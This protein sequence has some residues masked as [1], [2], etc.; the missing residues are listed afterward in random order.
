MA[1]AI[2]RHLLETLVNCPSC[3]QRYT[4]PRVLPSCGHTICSICLDNEW[5][6]KYNR[7]CPVKTCHKEICSTIGNLTDLPLNQ[8][9]LDLIKSCNFNVEANGKCQVCNQSPSF[10]KCSHCCL[11]V[12]FEC[13][14]QHRRET[15]TILTNNINTLEQEYLNMNDY[16]NHAR[17]KLTETRQNSLDTIRNHYTRLIEELRHA[18]VTNEELVERQAVTWNNELEL[19]INEYKRRCEDISTTIQEL[20]T[21]IT[22]WST[23]EQFKQLQMKLNH[24]E[25]D[26][27]EAN[28]IFHE[29]LPDMKIFEVDHD[30]IQKKKK[31]I[32][33]IDSPSQ[34]DELILGNGKNHLS[35][36]SGSI[37]IQHLDD[38]TSSA[39]SSSNNEPVQ[40]L[41]S[42]HGRILKKKPTIIGNHYKSLNTL[43]N[44]HHHSTNTSDN[45][46]HPNDVLEQ[47]QQP[48]LSSP[49]TT[50]NHRSHPP[51]SN[52]SLSKTISN[53][54]ADL[55]LSTNNNSKT[56]ST[57][58][59]V[60]TFQS[61]LDY[62]N[63]ECY[64]K[65]PLSQ[66]YD[67]GMLAITNTDLILMYNKDKNSLVIFDSNGHE[68][69]RIQW[70]DGEIKDLCIY[71]DDSIIII[72][73]HKQAS[74]KPLECKLYLCNLTRKQLERERVVERGLNSQ[75]VTSDEKLIFYGSEKGCNKSKVSVF[76]HDLQVQL[77]FECGVE[78]R[79]LVVDAQYCFILGKR[80]EREPGRYFVEKRQKHGQL[81]RRIDLYELNVDNVNRLIIDPIS[82]G[83]IV[84]DGGNKK[85]WA[86]GSDGEKK[87]VQYRP[88]PWSVGFLTTDTL[89][90]LHAGCLTFHIVNHN[91]Q[92]NNGTKIRNIIT[93]AEKV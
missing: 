70:S 80:R 89:V 75:R 2:P 31:K 72:G 43:A 48:L 83:V 26:I 84:T 34:T 11:Y 18:Q 13:A 42:N 87:S 20:R 29:R 60:S 19:V 73:E 38:S 86:I 30:D 77:T 15:L 57:P 45:R 92:I 27:R 22:D 78:I 54:I 76:D 61:K 5:K 10:V 66:N 55:S 37:R 49:R 62:C 6:E 93:N 36:L 79:S 16:I 74:S 14:N 46:T 12:C 59:R 47:Q 32:N 8:T 40:P 85:I 21:T 65:I 90:I 7:F 88:W 24:L 35:I 44:H 64:K 23:I 25:E 69:E 50:I 41:T 4:E 58:V 71:H 91:K 52:H 1:A 67:W 33:Q 3:S 53:S 56:C 82:G 17:E 81:V 51:V 39:S 9:V 28:E 63:N 68:N